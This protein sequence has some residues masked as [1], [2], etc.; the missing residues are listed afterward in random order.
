MR[1]RFLCALLLVATA[2]APG[3]ALAD[4]QAGGNATDGNATTTPAP[5]TSTASP[6]NQTH[7][8]NVQLGRTLRITRWEYANDSFAVTL[9]A[10][11]PMQVKVTDSGAVLEALGE[12]GGARAIDVP[13]RGYFVERGRTTITFAPTTVDGQAAITV[14]SPDG[15]VLLRTGQIGTTGRPSV[16]WQRVQLLIGLT[17]LA[18]AAGTYRYIRNK[19]ESEERE[20]ERIL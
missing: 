1:L 5:T 20:V 6:A 15:A 14:A 13:T 7:R 9:R 4:G 16:P 11:V 12:D 3:L 8:V 17:F 10:R 2:V 19:H 18:T